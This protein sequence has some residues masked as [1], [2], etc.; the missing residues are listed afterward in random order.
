[1]G[2]MVMQIL[3]GCPHWHNLHICFV[4]QHEK[5]QVQHCDLH[6][7]PVLCSSITHPVMVRVVICAT[8]LHIRIQ[9]RS[10]KVNMMLVAPQLTVAR[11]HCIAPQLSGVVLCGQWLRNP[12]C[13]HY[14]DIDFTLS[15]TVAISAFTTNQF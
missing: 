14:I 4:Y 6:F 3:F 12:V 2:T 7:L 10:L 13:L 8:Q 1:M 15:S 11:R 9:L 5:V